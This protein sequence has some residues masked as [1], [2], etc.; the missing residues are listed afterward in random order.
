[1]EKLNQAKVAGLAKEAAVQ[2]RAVTAERDELREKVARLELRQDCE[3][4]AS[5]MQRKGLSDE[6]T[7][8]LIETLEKKAH[9][10]QLENVRAA[11]DM[12]GPDMWNK[13]ASPSSDEGKNHG[14]DVSGF[15]S[16]I[17]SLGPRPR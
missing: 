15:E 13:L 7:E 17:M 1:M 5:E 2:L 11:V 14:G 12:V 6:P 10:G 9:A 4:I 3:K 16:V 8:S